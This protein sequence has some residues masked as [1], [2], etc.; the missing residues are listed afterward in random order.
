M[1]NEI[2]NTQYYLSIQ[3]FNVFVTLHSEVSGKSL[4][5]ARI[6]TERL[7]ETIISWFLSKRGNI[8]INALKIQLKLQSQSKLKQLI[9]QLK[10]FK[11][12]NKQL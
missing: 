3:T 6:L 9:F 2:D 11:F 5:D 8:K 12:L 4:K 7:H 1:Y 10:C